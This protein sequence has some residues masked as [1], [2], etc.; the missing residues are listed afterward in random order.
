MELSNIIH[1]LDLIKP[2]KI[3]YATEQYV[4]ILSMP[5]I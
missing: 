3:M 4:F 1:M 2:F 5:E